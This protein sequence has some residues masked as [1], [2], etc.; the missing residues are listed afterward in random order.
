MDDDGICKWLGVVVG[1][2]PDPQIWPDPIKN[3]EMS[4]G[5]SWTME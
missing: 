5:K 3:V 1:E 2:S 4:T